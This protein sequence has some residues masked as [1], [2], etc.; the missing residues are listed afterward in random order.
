MRLANLVPTAGAFMTKVDLAHRV[1]REAILTGVMQPGETINPKAVAEELG[2]SFIPVR[3]ALRR[4]EQD[5]LILI[6]PHVGATV[7]EVKAEEIQETM[8]IR[9]ELEVLATMLAAQ[10][11]TA[12]TL[13]RL[14]HLSEEMDACVAAEDPER[15]GVLNRE[16]H[17]T[18]YRSSPFQRLFSMIESLWDQ[19]PLARSLFALIPSRMRASQQGHREMLAALERGDADAAEAIMRQQKQT[20]LAALLSLIALNDAPA[21]A[22]EEDSHPTRHVAGNP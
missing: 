14:R 8:L 7:R 16:F 2:M 4:L 19:I 5:S 21:G 11:I 10:H 15:Y 18:L 20:A 17:L 22:P 13:V 12:D 3:E 6:T 9:G 1:L